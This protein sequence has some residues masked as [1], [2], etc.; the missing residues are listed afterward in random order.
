LE[1]KNLEAK[2]NKAGYCVDL[3][4]EA[5]SFSNKGRDLTVLTAK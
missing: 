3:F 1:E 2:M 4:N 5:G